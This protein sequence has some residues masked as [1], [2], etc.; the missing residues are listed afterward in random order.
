MRVAFWVCIAA[1]AASG[2]VTS[3]TGGALGSS[4]SS[5][6]LEFT[7]PRFPTGAPWAFSGTRGKVVLVDVWAT[8]C[9]PCAAALPQYAALQGE[10]ARQPFEVVTISVDED[11]NALLRFVNETQLTLPVLRD[12]NASLTERLLKVKMMPTSVLVDRRG[13]V[14]HQHEGALED[15]VALKAQVTALLAESP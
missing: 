12:P 2:C 8:W 15:I 6:A 10:L 14:R 5:D 11:V 13:R 3:A 1:M 4:A 9:E 7:L